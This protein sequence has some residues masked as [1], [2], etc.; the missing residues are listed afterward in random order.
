MQI[1]SCQA[2]ST[3]KGAVARLLVLRIRLEWTTEDTGI[4]L[5]GKKKN[6]FQISLF[7][8]LSHLW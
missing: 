6:T 3:F 1:V 7:A 5:R 2:L 8:Y 4:K